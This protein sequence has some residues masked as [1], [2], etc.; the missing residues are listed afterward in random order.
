MREQQ[1]ILAALPLGVIL[2]ARFADDHLALE[3][4]DTGV[5][6]PEDQ[7]DDIFEI[8]EEWRP[9]LRAQAVQNVE[10]PAPSAILLLATGLLGLRRQR[11]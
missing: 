5:G 3:V 6:I 4:T 7:L 9:N 2:R 11:R 8:A 1:L 10:V